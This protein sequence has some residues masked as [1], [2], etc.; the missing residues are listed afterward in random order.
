[1][2]HPSVTDELEVAYRREAGRIV[3]ALVRDLDDYALA[4]D[5][6]SDA[7][8][9]ALSTWPDRG[10]PR[11]PAAWLMTTARHKALDRIRRE[12]L[13]ARKTALLE[14]WALA[15]VAA[16][17][18]PPLPASADEE[19]QLILLCCHPALAVEAQVALTLRSL[20]GLSTA[21]LAR[22]FLLPQA[23]MAQRLVRAKRKIRDAGIPF[24]MP[25]DHELPDRLAAALAV[26]Y[27]VFSEGY[28]ATAGDTLVRADL[29][30]EAL[31]LGALLV[32]LMPDE[33]EALALQ[34]LM[35][36]H[37]A[38]RATRVG[39]DGSLVR[40]GDQDRSQWDRDRID[41]AGT[42]LDR[43]VRQGRAGPYQLQAAIAALHAQAPSGE[44]TDWPQIAAL[45]AELQRVA[46][47][48]VVRLNAAVATAEATGLEAGLAV[49]GGLVDELDS[50]HLLHAARADLLRRL[51]RGQEALAA[52]R[53]ALSLARTLPEQRYLQLRVDELEATNAET[54][55]RPLRPP[56]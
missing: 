18:D 42:L 20:C 3:A 31:H 17:A 14:R 47:S 15:E 11:N 5:A 35:L 22:A 24:R 16:S 51:G 38:R 29:C 40:L 56:R 30:D 4:E 12:K 39:E 8:A 43:A 52:Y 32:E 23:T 28:R 1:M 7:V 45:Y 49:L 50:H 13:L 21:E 36:F 41:D 55:L 9:M 25:A 53:R 34:A 33:P 2:A 37:D 48:P 10:I 26:V 6:F 46:P 54:P 27:L 44:A 19:L